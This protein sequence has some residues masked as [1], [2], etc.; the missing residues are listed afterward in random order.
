MPPERGQS[1]RVHA[2]PK[3]EGVAITT[4]VRYA[5]PGVCRRNLIGCRREIMWC[6]TER[7]HRMPVDPEPDE[8]G[9][10]TSHW[11]TCPQADRF[12]REGANKEI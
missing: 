7:G 11:A 12:R 9:I 3:R 8:D 4:T 2:G 10:Y 1:L 6:T 5:G